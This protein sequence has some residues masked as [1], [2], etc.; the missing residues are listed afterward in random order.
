MKTYFITVRTGSSR[1]PNKSIL[2]INGKAT[3]QYL[4]LAV[5]VEELLGQL[6]D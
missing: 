6:V 2:H 5:S 4:I 3:I 1:L